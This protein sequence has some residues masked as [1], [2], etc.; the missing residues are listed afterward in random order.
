MVQVVRHALL[1]FSLLAAAIPAARAEDPPQLYSAVPI[2]D[3]Q[4]AMAISKLD[5]LVTDMMQR[6]GVPGI[7]VAV[8]ADGKLSYAKGFGVREA[9]KADK[10]D[11]D[12]VFQIASVSKSVGATV[13]AREVAAKKVSWNTP[14]TNFLPWFALSDPRVTDMVTIGDF[15]AHRSGLPDHAGDDLEDLGYDRRAVLERLRFLP[16]KPFRDNYDYTNFGPTA[17]GE[18]V[19][20]A[21][22]TDWATLSDVAIYKPLGMTRTSSRFADFMARENRAVLHARINGVWTPKY[23]RQPDAQSPAG[24][25]S[26]SVN[27]MAK[28][29]SMVLADGAPLMPADA[30]LP[31]LSPQSVSSRP[32]APADR[33]GFYGFGFNVGVSATGRVTLNHSGAFYLGGATNVFMVPSAGVGIVVLSNAAPVGAVEAVSLSFVDL[34]QEGHVTRDWLGV[35][36]PIFAK[37][38]APLGHLAGQKPP[39]SS[40]PRTGPT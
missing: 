30:L 37:F 23:Q 33:A 6:T 2:P 12:T 8:V 34:V 1:A 13:V 11:P 7:A 35:L 25:V 31:A 4:I 29:M 32:Q 39:A 16:L 27:D 17:S 15:Y 18:A 36:S 22:G 5:G 38:E 9:N 21:A 40:A 26:S 3:G 14:I 19:A 28:W 10:V 20:A 24:G